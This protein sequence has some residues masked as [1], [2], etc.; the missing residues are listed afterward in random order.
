[1]F[2]PCICIVGA[3]RDASLAGEEQP[4]EAAIELGGSPLPPSLQHPE[5]MDSI[6]AMLRLLESS[7]T[8]R[9][10]VTAVAAAAPVAIEEPRTPASPQA[11][12]KL[13]HDNEAHAG[14]R[15]WLSAH[16]TGDKCSICLEELVS[17]PF[18]R[19]PCSLAH[20]FHRKCLLRWLEASDSCPLCR[21]PLG[22]EEEV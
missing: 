1:V 12:H 7:P 8:P 3:L 4:D 21:E 10:S 6:S 19:M 16:E 5:V 18:L 14:D 17:T 20:L 13:V 2:I 22:N 11:I 15:A 9:G